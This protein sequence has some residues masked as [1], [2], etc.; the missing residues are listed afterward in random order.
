MHMFADALAETQEMDTDG[1]REALL[2]KTFNAPQGQIKID[3]DNNH[4]YLQSL[5][6]KVNEEGEFIVQHKVRRAIKPDPYLV[7][8]AINDWS[9]R[10][11]KV[12]VR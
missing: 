2:G 12:L 3:A 4:T 1:L 10:T 8:P 9:F 11:Q 7:F 6:A 5:I